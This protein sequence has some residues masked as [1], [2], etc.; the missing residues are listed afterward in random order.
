MGITI[1]L[2]DAS[3]ISNVSEKSKDGKPYFAIQGKQFP[4]KEGFG[5]M[6]FFDRHFAIDLK[7]A[8]V[9]APFAQ[10][11]TLE[12]EFN[13]EGEVCEFK[14]VREGNGPKAIKDLVKIKADYEARKNG[15]NTA[16]P[17]VSYTTRR[18]VAGN[19]QVGQAG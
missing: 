19:E 9:K 12:V 18:P 2:Y 17:G 8:T 10:Y 1:K 16:V 4:K 5:D 6:Y 7:E 15:G 3:V 13:Y 11:S 14:V